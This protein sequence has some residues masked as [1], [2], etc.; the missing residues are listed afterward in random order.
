MLE[1]DANHFQDKSNPLPTKDKQE[2]REAVFF[3]VGQN[4][5]Q[6]YILNSKNKNGH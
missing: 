4:I 5:Q 2:E 6:N 3:P 1:G